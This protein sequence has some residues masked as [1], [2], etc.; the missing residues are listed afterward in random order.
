MF[1]ITDYENAKG[2]LK[3][4]K[5]KITCG[6]SVEISSDILWEISRLLNKIVADFEKEN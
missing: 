2:C 6:D 4:I 1:D 5:E 3:E